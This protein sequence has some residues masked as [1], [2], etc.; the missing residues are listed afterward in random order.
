M[1]KRV[2]LCYTGDLIVSV[3]PHLCL[4]GSG[5]VLILYLIVYVCVCVWCVVRIMKQEKDSS[6]VH[7]KHITTVAK[8]VIPLLTPFVR[9]DN[10]HHIVVASPTQL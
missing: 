3:M 5:P 2:T 9:N 10:W 6:S 8:I 4:W 7:C 1:A